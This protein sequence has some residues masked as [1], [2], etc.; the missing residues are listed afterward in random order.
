LADVGDNNN[1]T[2]FK[3]PRM[4]ELMAKYAASF[5]PKERVQLLRQLDAV[6]VN[7][8]HYVLFWTVPAERLAFWNK[9][10][11]PAGFLTRIG[12]WNGDLALGPGVERLWWI[13]PAKDRQLKKAL[14]DPSVK[15]EVGPLED[16]YWLTYK[17]K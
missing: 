2:G 17:S 12:G 5:D 1:F 15:L 8:Y 6:M 4:D 9:F 3:D 7:L 11:Q 14:T 16:K 13:D 10:G